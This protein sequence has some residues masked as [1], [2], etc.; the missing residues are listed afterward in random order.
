[1]AVKQPH[2]EHEL[3]LAIVRRAGN[4]NVKAVSDRMVMATAIVGQ[5]LG[6]GVAVKGGSSMLLRYGSENA[7]FTGDFDATRRIDL[8]VFLKGLRKRLEDG[9]CGFTGTLDI[10]PQA[11]PRGVLFDYVMQPIRVR[12]NYRGKSWC[13]V[14]MEMTLGSA[15]C[16]DSFDTVEP[17]EETVSIFRDLGFP[18]PGPVYVMK[19]DHQVAQKLRGA[20]CEGSDRA[21]DLVDL[22][23]ILQREE[24]YMPRIRE[25]CQR[26]FRGKKCP[27]WPPMIVKGDRWNEIYN[28]AKQDLPVLP[29]VEEAIVWT[30]D[31][32]A[33][34]DAAQ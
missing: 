31:L 32:I 7:R 12:L 8:D 11:N 6:E 21:H 13:S 17:N 15:G 3:E 28:E 27:P 23:L 24:L 2:N 33:K 1:M 14:N 5:L 34:I 9:W 20:S 25:I 22:Q 16:A 26:I 4:S 30:N 29:T 19:L 10:L 18:S